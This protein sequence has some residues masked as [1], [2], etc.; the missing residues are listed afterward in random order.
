MVTKK[1]TGQR[2]R[3]YVDDSGLDGRSLRSPVENAIRTQLGKTI[4]VETDVLTNSVG[5][6]LAG[7]L[8]MLKELPVPESQFRLDEV[9]FTL[10]I[11]ARGKVSVLS[12]LSASAAGHVGLTFTLRREPG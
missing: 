3:V 2:I 10:G 5:D 11:D 1:S 12:A 8:D 9:T 7:L 4:E 6:V